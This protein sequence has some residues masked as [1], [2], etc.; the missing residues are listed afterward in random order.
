ML[1]RFRKLESV[2]N[3]IPVGRPKKS[4]REIE[5]FFVSGEAQG[6][7]RSRVAAIPR[8][9]DPKFEERSE[10]AEKMFVGLLQQ[11]GWFLDTIVY[12][13]LHAWDGRG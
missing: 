8:M 2:R 7:E 13:W 6:F 4:L 10:M 1:F 9:R 12:Q 3:T 11:D 5:G